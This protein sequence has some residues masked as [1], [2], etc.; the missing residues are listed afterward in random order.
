MT[1]VPGPRRSPEQRR[2]DEEYDKRWAASHM[3]LSECVDDPAP[4]TPNPYGGVPL[5]VASAH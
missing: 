4:A 3:P 1:Y 2:Q 5:G